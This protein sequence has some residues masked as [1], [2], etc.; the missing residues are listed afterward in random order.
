M[1]KTQASVDDWI[2]TACFVLRPQSTFTVCKV[3]W[4]GGG[5]QLGIPA[6]PVQNPPACVLTRALCGSDL[7]SAQS[8]KRVDLRPFDCQQLWVCHC[9]TGSGKFR[10][11]T[12]LSPC[13]LKVCQRTG[14]SSFDGPQRWEQMWSMDTTSQVTTSNLWRFSQYILESHHKL[15]SPP[16]ST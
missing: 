13:E 9:I 10:T 16:L 8:I 5:K 14:L 15:P 12:R 7:H 6:R 1:P 11:A 2:C 4:Q 3:A